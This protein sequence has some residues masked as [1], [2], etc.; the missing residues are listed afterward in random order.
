MMAFTTASKE[1]DFW[2]SN[3]GGHKLNLGTGHRRT[4]HPHA[5]HG[6][7]LSHEHHLGGV[8]ETPTPGVRRTHAN[9]HCMGVLTLTLRT[10][11]HT[12]AHA[13]TALPAAGPT[14]GAQRAGGWRGTRGRNRAAS[15]AGARGAHRRPACET[16][17]PISPRACVGGWWGQSRP[18]LGSICRHFLST[19]LP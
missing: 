6:R 1:G 9:T 5:G 7:Q 14:R 10:R 3:H 12:S 4:D 11:V 18:A 15:D 13:R 19:W 8:P 17:P 16:H 2:C